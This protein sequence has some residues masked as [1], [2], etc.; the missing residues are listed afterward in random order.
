M[1]SKLIKTEAPLPVTA[2]PMSLV[3][4]N[5]PVRAGS[6]SPTADFG[7]RCLDLSE[8]LVEHPYSTFLMRVAGP[9]MIGYGIDDGDL[10]VVD[11]AILPRHGGI[12]VAV[13]DGDYTVKALHQVGDT[14]MLKAGNP[15]FPDIIPH[16]GQTL[17]I[18]GVVTSCIKRFN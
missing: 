4:A 14:L 12:V 16:E 1:Y 15:N 8:I 9:S 11:R 13:V 2:S 7:G 17:E 18:W 6:P 10:I 5:S 3:L